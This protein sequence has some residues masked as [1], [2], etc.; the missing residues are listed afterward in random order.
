MN[1]EIK[2][3]EQ[4]FK[5]QN[6]IYSYDFFKPFQFIESKLPN[7]GDF[8]KLMVT[9][10]NEMSNLQSKITTLK[11]EVQNINIQRQLDCGSLGS[12]DSFHSAKSSF[13]SR[14]GSEN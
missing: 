10:G 11:M 12:D 3:L 2:L 14:R 1:S 8:V 13:G 6:R 4:Q 9:R 7:H 5:L